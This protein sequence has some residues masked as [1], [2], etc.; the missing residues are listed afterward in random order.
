MLA[1]SPFYISEKCPAIIVN[2]V[3]KE[4]VQPGEVKYPGR[5]LC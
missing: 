2:P 1:T 5:T 3:E 4:G